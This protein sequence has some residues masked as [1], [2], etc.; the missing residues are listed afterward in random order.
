VE[1]TLRSLNITQLS[2]LSIA[3]D[4]LVEGENVDGVVRKV[5]EY[6]LFVEIKGSKISGLC[7]KSEVCDKS[8]IKLCMSSNA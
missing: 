5:E 7:H 3:F 6:G 2:S 8:P 1:L 4:D